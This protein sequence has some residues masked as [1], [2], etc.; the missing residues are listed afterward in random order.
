MVYGR[1]GI[2]L[3]TSNLEN[4]I[5]QDGPGLVFKIGDF[6]ICSDYIRNYFL[7][8][9]DLVSF[10]LIKELTDE[11]FSII[12]ILTY[13]NYK[14]PPALIDIDKLIEQGDINII[15]QAVKDREEK[16]TKLKSE[17]FDLEQDLFNTIYN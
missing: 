8:E 13:S 12:E 7:D 3:E 14:F 11:E 16:I 10:E 6:I 9:K 2:Y 15:C 1:R 4:W 5:N 17:I